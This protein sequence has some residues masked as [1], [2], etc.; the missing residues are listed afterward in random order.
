MEKKIILDKTNI[1]KEHICCAISD[2][3][4]KVS[5]LNKFGVFRD[6]TNIDYSK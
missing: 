3:K 5:C 4:C 6:C 1:D 2:K